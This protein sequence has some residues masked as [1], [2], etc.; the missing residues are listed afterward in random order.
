M[1]RSFSAREF[2]L[3]LREIQGDL[4]AICG[5][6]QASVGLPKLKESI[7]LLGG[8]VLPRSAESMILILVGLPASYFG[9]SGTEKIY[10]GL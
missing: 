4:Q 9:L 10:Y 6:S 1:S 7:A 2:D 8:F 5:R 3:C